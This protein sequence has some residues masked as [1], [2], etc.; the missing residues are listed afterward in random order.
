MVYNKTK[1][2]I[3][4]I[5]IFNQLFF[6]NVFLFRSKIVESSSPKNKA[7][8]N[9]VPP[10]SFHSRRSTPKKTVK[11]PEKN[12]TGTYTKKSIFIFVK[13]QLLIIEKL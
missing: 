1:T 11:T 3:I 4:L 12:K 13:I 7:K 5:L 10:P 8:R 9:N 2:P 6:F